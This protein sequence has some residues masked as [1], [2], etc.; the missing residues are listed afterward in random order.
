MTRFPVTVREFVLAGRFAGGGAFGWES[1]ADIAARI[2]LRNVTWPD[3][4]RD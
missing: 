4:R 2:S 3:M 1:E